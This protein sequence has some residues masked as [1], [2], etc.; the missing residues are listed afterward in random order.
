[1][2]Q[3]FLEFMTLYIVFLVG[4]AVA[5]YSLFYDIV[6]SE[7]NEI[8]PQFDGFMVSLLSTFR[9][10]AGDWD[11]EVFDASGL[12]IAYAMFVIY[13]LL[14][15]IMLLNL[16]IAMMSNSYELVKFSAEREWLNVFASYILDAQKDFDKPAA[17]A[18][19]DKALSRQ[20][21]NLQN[22][23]VGN[24]TPPPG[25]DTI[26]RTKWGRWESANEW[27]KEKPAVDLHV[28]REELGHLI[29]A[30]RD[31]MKVEFMQ[32]HE[33]MEKSTTNK[34]NGGN[35]GNKNALDATEDSNVVKR[36]LT[37]NSLKTYKTY[38]VSSS[39]NQ[40]IN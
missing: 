32:M 28:I 38:T 21:E 19:L 14:S 26:D 10:M 35:E 13:I 6:G 3:D 2:V 17:R 1:M 31:E 30:L 5:F 36:E 23:M 39:F 8:N 22:V 24:A 11:W 12:G 7:A 29:F 4:F 18:I 25:L 27:K 34:T 33:M 15:N 40:S 9:M 37:R 16:L 20:H